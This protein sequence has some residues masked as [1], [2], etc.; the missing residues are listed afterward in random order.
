MK[1]YTFEVV[2]NE[3]NCEY[4][5]DLIKEGKSGCD[6]LKK[7]IRDAIYNIGFDLGDESVEG[8]DGTVKLKKY[9]ND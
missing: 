2:I 8:Y 4:W 3:G 1:K 9:E 6:E 5:E 7:A